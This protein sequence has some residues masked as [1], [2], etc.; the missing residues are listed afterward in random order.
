MHNYVLETDRLILRQ[1]TASD[2]EAVFVWGSDPKVNR[3]MPY[4][5]YT[6]V[7]K[8]RQWLNR[9]EQNDKEYE[10]GFVLKENG[11]LIGSGGVSPHNDGL[12]W[13]VGYNIRSDYWG[14]G[15]ATEA[16]KCMINFAYS[17]FGIRDFSANHATANPAS[18]RILQKC[19]MKFDHIGEYSRF[20]GSE[21]F[22]ADFYKL[23]ID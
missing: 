11:L 10:F 12:H 18:G 9:V 20:D 14:K 8:V 13:E 23:H 5:I 22:K 3:Y 7:E 6:D 15:L 2:A 1:L 19:G 16:A 21:T 4:P 17:E